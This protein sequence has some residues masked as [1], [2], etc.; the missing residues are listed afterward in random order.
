MEPRRILVGVTVVL[1][2][3]IILDNY[4]ALTQTG[5]KRMANPTVTTTTAATRAHRDWDWAAVAATRDGR[6]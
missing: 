6:R 1:M 2:F 4:V 5:T 3:I